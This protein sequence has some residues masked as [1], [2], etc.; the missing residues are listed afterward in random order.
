MKII[1]LSLVTCPHRISIF[2]SSYTACPNE[3]VHVF[4]FFIK[5]FMNYFMVLCWVSIMDLEVLLWWERHILYWICLAKVYHCSF[6]TGF[7]KTTFKHFFVP[8]YCLW[9]REVYHSWDKVPYW[10]SIKL[11]SILLF[12]E[13][14][15]LM[16]LLEEISSKIS[17]CWKLCKLGIEIDQ[18]IYFFFFQSFLHRTGL[19]FGQL[20]AS[21]TPLKHNKQSRV[22]K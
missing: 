7:I 15:F 19:D 8:F 9:V 18:K 16:T 5:E 17:F 12:Y 14:S 21:V 6:C 1:V 4:I 2:R 13:I 3:S 20:R 22:R 11:F 10:I